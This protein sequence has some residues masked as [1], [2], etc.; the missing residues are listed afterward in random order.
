MKKNYQKR[1]YVK[2]VTSQL[3]K[4]DCLLLKLGKDI[5]AIL[6]LSVI[7]IVIISIAVVSL[8]SFNSMFLFAVIIKSFISKISLK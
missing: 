5:T 4:Q 8:P 7:M 6:I 2:V 1:S 3:H